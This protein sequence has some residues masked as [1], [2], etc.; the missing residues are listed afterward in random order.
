MV[1]IPQLAQDIKRLVMQSNPDA[2][3]D[4][5]ESLAKYY[6]IDALVEP[7][8]PDGEFASQ[9]RKQTRRLET[10]FGACLHHQCPR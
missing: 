3:F 9:S 7:N 1:S 5:A 6:F 2:P 10:T 8:T 4:I